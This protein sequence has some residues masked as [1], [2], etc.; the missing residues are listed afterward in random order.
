[1]MLR[2]VPPRSKFSFLEKEKYLNMILWARSERIIEIA[3]SHELTR[4]VRVK[5]SI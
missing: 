5:L 3:S 1:M 2:K 4:D